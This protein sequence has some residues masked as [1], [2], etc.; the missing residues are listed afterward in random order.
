MTKDEYNKN[1][2]IC[3]SCGSEIIAKKSDKTSDVARKKFCNLTC[4]AIHNNGNRIRKKK[5]DRFCSCGKLLNRT[6][7]SGVCRPCS[8]SLKE[9][10]IVNQT[11]ASLAGRRNY[12][13]SWRS[14]ISRHAVKVFDASGL[15]KK[16]SVCGYTTRV[17]ICHIR[18]VSS[19]SEDAPITEINSLDN[20]IPLC[21][22]HHW[23]FDHGI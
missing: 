6:N 16:C 4:S 11:K 9:R 8:F 18:S 7:S 20:L 15:D 2:N 14:T 23:E 17:D 3:L 12:Y 21:P 19:F 5:P 10:S 1:P 13:N 22:N